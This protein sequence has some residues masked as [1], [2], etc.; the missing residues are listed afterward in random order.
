[1]EVLNILMS[2]KGNTIIITGVLILLLFVVFTV[3][4]AVVDKAPIGPLDS[5]VGL[6]TINGAFRDY[7]GGNRVA[8][9]ISEIMGLAAIPVAGSFALLGTYQLITRRSLKAVDGIIILLGGLYIAVSTF[10]FIFVKMVI[11]YRPIIEEAG[12]GLEASYPSSHTLMALCIYIS[13]AMAVGWYIKGNAGKTISA[14]LIIMAIVAVVS[15]TLSGVHWITDITGSLI[16]SSA[17]LT[18]FAG[19]ICSLRRRIHSL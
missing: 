16:L 8:Y 12:N 10:Y 18:I 13:A 7:V 3:I 1:M 6:S 4:V 2:D 15:R 5:V 19:G 14:I 17:I 9:K 11:N